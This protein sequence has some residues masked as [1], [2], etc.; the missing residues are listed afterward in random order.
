LY[1]PFAFPILAVARVAFSEGVPYVATFD[2]ARPG[3]TG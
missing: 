1:Y 2:G 3:P